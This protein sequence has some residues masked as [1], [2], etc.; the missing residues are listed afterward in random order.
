MIDYKEG[1]Y[2]CRIACRLRG[3]LIPR[4]I[5]VSLPAAVFA[6]LLVTFEAEISPVREWVGLT[7][8]KVTVIWTAVTAPLLTM[9]GFRTS[10]A[11]RRFWE[12]T[13]LLHAMRGEWFESASALVTFTVPTKQLKPE[14]VSDFRHTVMRLMSLCHGSALDE[15]KNTETED[16]EVL[17]IRGLDDKT[18]H[19]LSACKERNFNRVEVVLHMIKVLVVN[20]QAEGVINI[21]PPI[22]TRVFQTL[23]RGFVNLLNAKKIKDTRF[24]F[25]HAQIIAIML[26]VMIF[27][28]PLAMSTMLGHRG[29]SALAS[30]FPVFALFSLNYTAEELEMPFGEDAND[31][32][33]GLF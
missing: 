16:Y 20:A 11:M 14:Q 15:L 32:P 13:S 1:D 19:I 30:F 3:S 23:S 18:I 6:V 9:I 12:G 8:M 25:P 28:T 4:C 17:D 26:I 27:F 10:E 29:W 31:L 7:A 21:P 5:L 24:P 2:T 33:L 22:L